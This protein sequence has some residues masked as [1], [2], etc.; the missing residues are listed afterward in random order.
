[1]LDVLREL[2]PENQ[3]RLLARTAEALEPGGLLLI[4]EV[5]ADRGLHFWRRRL[6]VRI[7][8]LTRG[9]WRRRHHF[10]S[11]DEWAELLSGL[12]L[13][14]DAAPVWAGSYYG[15]RIIEARKPSLKL[16]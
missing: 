14:V 16:P 3:E 15:D 9:G 5:D 2:S 6:G 10:R 13:E 12:G 11:G 8:S 7:R 1:M 4:R